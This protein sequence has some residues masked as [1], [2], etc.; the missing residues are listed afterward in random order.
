M[1]V[2]RKLVNSWDERLE[3]LVSMQHLYWIRDTFCYIDTD[4]IPGFFHLL[5]NHIFTA[6]SE[7]IYVLFAGWEGPYSEKL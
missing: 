4:E 2:N 1:N 5:K 6:R 3:N 7:D